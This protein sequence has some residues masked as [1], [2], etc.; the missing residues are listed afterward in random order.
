M[1][2]QDVRRIERQQR[3]ELSAVDR[4]VARYRQALAEAR[5]EK[6][7]A[8]TGPGNRL[9][10]DVLDTLVPAIR[11]EQERTLQA[12]TESKAGNEGY[13]LASLAFLSL[14]PE[15]LALIT[16]RSAF[17][18][19]QDFRAATALALQIASRVKLEREWELWGENERVRAKETETV[20]LV[21]L[22]KS[23]VKNVRARS[24]RAWMKWAD[25][26]DTLDWSLE[27]KTK[28]GAHL[29]NLLVQHGNGWFEFAYVPHS[30]R[31]RDFTTKRVVRLTENGR[32]FLDDAHAQS[33]LT[34]PWLMPMVA[35]PKEWK[36]EAA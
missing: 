25:A 23:R 2:E 13:R 11:E 5:K 7:E 30:G 22:M 31:G 21:E 3:L 28:L 16:A 18:A 10:S 19:K 36:H 14:S 35:P 26:V 34:R 1:S 29:L 15:K 32:K 33:E 24:V 9:I 4:G 20:N 27:T 17:T 8:E 12:L 6:N